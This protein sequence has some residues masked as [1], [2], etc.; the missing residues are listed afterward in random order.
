MIDCKQ[1]DWFMTQKRILQDAILLG[2]KNSLR[3]SDIVTY[4]YMTW[5]NWEHWPLA[6]PYLK[7]KFQMKKITS[8]LKEKVISGVLEKL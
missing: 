7:Y 5:E 3:M 4:I 2:F 1:K 8:Y 6:Y